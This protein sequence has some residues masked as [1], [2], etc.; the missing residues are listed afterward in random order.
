VGVRIGSPRLWLEEVAAA[1]ARR[2]AAD[3]PLG[4]DARPARWADSYPLAGSRLAA[5]MLL[6]QLEE[7]TSA[8]GFGMYQLVLRD[9]GRVIGDIGFHGPPQ[10]DGA[11]EIGYAVVEEERG[12]GLAG[13][14]A[15]AVCGWAFNQ[16]AVQLIFAQTDIDNEPSGGVLRHT[17]FTDLGIQGERRTFVLTRADLRPR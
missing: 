5:R 12:R 7:G 11:V 2:L 6:G 14:A 10:R 16:P 17:G 13:E 9:G 15:V 8:T 1:E 4:G 3:P